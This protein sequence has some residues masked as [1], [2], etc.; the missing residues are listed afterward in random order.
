MTLPSIIKKA[1]FVAALLIVLLADAQK[2][3]VASNPNA[4]F[5]PANFADSNRAN[6]VAALFPVIEKIGAQ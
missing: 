5:Q 6:K 1:G 3:T 4:A 2:A